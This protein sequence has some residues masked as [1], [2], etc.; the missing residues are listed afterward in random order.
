MSETI[1]ICQNCGQRYI[2]GMSGT[3]LGCDSC[4]LII[5]NPVDHTIID[6]WNGTP[7]EEDSLTDMEK[8]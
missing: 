8:A 7:D 1:C 2:L 4:L 3:V 6:T 5:R